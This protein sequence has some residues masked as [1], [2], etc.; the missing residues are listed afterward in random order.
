MSKKTNIFIFALSIVFALCLIPTQFSFVQIAAV[1]LVERLKNDDINDPFWM[2]QMSAFGIMGLLFIAIFDLV[3][4]TQKGRQIF[5]NTIKDFRK[6]GVIIKENKKYLFILLGLYLLGYFTIIRANF[7]NIYIDDLG[8][9]IRGSREWMNFYRYI[10]EIGSIFVHTSKRLMDIAPLTQFIAI[11]FLAF[12]SFFSICIFNKGKFSFFACLASLPIGLFPYWLSNFSYRYDS[13]YMA[14]SFVISFVPFLFFEKK[15]TFAI[16]SVL[17]LLVM[18]FSYQASSGIYIML[19]ILCVIYK[20]LLEGERFKEI[21]KKTGVCILCYGLTLF[22]FM[23]IF[24]VPSEDIYVSETISI[25][26]IVPNTVGY[27][28][29]FLADFNRTPILIFSGLI[30]ILSAFGFIKNSKQNKLLSAFVVILLI[31]VAVPLSFGSYIVLE[32][33]SDAPRGMYGIGVLFSLLA[34]S[35]Y[36]QICGKGKIYKVISL[37]CLFCYSYC[38]LAFSFAYG[39]AQAEQKDYVK[40]R[41]TILL[42]DLAGI[43]EENGEPVEFIFVNDIGHANVVNNMIDVYPVM[44]KI[45]DPG[46][47]FS[48]ASQFAL[49]SMNF[50]EVVSGPD[51]DYDTSLPV[52]FENCYHKIQKKDNKYVITYKTPTLKVLKNKY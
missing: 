24:S 12:A 21:L 45:V 49:E 39:N 48:G 8:R 44:A 5:T 17:S 23:K 32:K 38:F 31:A 36:H 20:W 7:Y 33:P 42:Q 27:I 13:P 30:L 16:T 26:S 51:T 29:T 50:F 1:K 10:S 3:W 11:F 47:K 2:K 28:K 9:A 14:L 18:C 35:L 34:V 43:V 40:F 22:C 19:S 52:V 37:V 41:A 25:A 4:F 6:I 46:L 15:V